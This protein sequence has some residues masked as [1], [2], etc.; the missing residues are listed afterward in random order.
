MDTRKNITRVTTLMG[1]LI[2]ASA[3][4]WALVIIGTSYALRDTECYDKI[5]NYLVGGAVMHF[6][7]FGGLIPAVHKMLKGGKLVK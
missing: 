2:I 3:L 6:L 4:I 1:T 7:L 5:R